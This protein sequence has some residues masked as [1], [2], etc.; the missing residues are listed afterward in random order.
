MA[1]SSEQVANDLLSATKAFDLL[2]SNDLDEATKLFSAE[3]SPFH[4]MGAGVC[5]FLEAALGMEATAVASAAETLALSEAGAKKQLK[6]AKASTSTTRFP[7]GTE[8]ELIHSD[9]AILNGITNALSESYMGYLQCLYALNNAHSKYTRLYKTVYP[10]GLDNYATPST[11]K[12]PSPAPSIRSEVSTAP[13]KARSGFFSRFTGSTLSVPA[14]NTVAVT[15]PEG[16]LEELIMSGAAFGYGMFNLVF[17]LLPPSI[18]GVVGFLGFKHDRKLALRALAVSAAQNDVHSVFAGLTLMTYHGVVL[19]LSGYQADEQHI[20]KQYRAVVDKVDARYPTGSLWILNR[21]KIL[22]MSYDA[23]AAI[24]VLQAGLKPD[25]PHTF[26]QADALLIFE[27][28]W[29]LLSQ[30]RYKEAADAFIKVTEIN[31]WSH[32][33]YYFI[34]GGCYIS[35]K[36]YKKAQEYFDKVP[37][38]LEKKKIGG[39]DLPTEVFIK[40]KLQFYREKQKRKTGSEANFAE[41]IRISPAEELG[42]FWNTHQRIGQD[43]VQQHVDEFYSYSPA[44]TIKSAL[45]PSTTSATENDLDTPDEVA[46]RSLILGIVHRTAQEFETSRAFLKDAIA[47]HDAVQICTWAAGIA[48]FELAVLDLKQLE[49]KI[50]SEGGDETAKG[51]ELVTEEHRAMWLKTFKSVDEK[52]DEA[53]RLSGQNVDLSS[54]LGMRVAMLKDEVLL[55]KENI[56]A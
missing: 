50:K 17:S 45:A 51:V 47:Q 4:Q 32:G 44:I 29:T 31:S 15:T 34:A 18:R 55:K 41:S 37:E 38:L 13:T 5:A 3:S 2:F 43:I 40:K 1:S 6:I 30:R 11:S 28:A 54:R 56:G 9:A 33:T 16:P 48:T 19:L 35:L 22:R 7:P 27:L 8:W 49:A 14:T 39:K 10:N 23:S 46:I 42:I 21:A 12:S 52:L 26:V 24:E 53:L 36:D 25:R 20:L